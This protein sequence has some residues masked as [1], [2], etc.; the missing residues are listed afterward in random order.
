MSA[1]SQVFS[2]RLSPEVASALASLARARRHPVRRMA[3][4]LIEDGLK[5]VVLPE[6]EKALVRTNKEKGKGDAV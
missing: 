2:V 6:D 1:R 3:A 5:S 4:Y